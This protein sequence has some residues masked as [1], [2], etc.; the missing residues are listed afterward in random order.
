MKRNHMI[1]LHLH[2]VDIFVITMMNVMMV[3]VHTLVTVVLVLVTVV[4]VHTL[5]TV[6]IVHVLLAIVNNLMIFFV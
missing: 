1:I 2:K 4:I 5:V 3:L 6:V